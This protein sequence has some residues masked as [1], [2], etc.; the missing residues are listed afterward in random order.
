MNEVSLVKLDVGYLSGA[1]NFNEL[2]ISHG[3]QKDTV[4]WQKRKRKEKQKSP[5]YEEACPGVEKLVDVWKDCVR[6]K[7]VKRSTKVCNCIPLSM[8]AHLEQIT[9]ILNS[10]LKINWFTNYKYA[11][12]GASAVIIHFYLVFYAESLGVQTEVNCGLR[13][14]YH[15]N[16]RIRVHI[17]RTY[18]KAKVSLE[19]HTGQKVLKNLKWKLT[20]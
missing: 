2:S 14:V 9:I 19:T 6:Q 10:F 15:A 17:F 13:S 18:I 1:T 7:C 11:W 3:C 12:T 5:Q 8:V 16:I 4:K 20:I